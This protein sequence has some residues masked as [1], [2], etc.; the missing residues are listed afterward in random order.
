M[1]LY[2]VK[3]HIEDHKKTKKNGAPEIFVQCL[4]GGLKRKWD[5]K[6]E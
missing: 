3:S 1:D 5:L 2:I 4:N 6:A